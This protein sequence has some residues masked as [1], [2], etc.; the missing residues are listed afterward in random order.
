MLPS[1]YGVTQASSSIRKSRLE[2]KPSL[3]PKPRRPGSTDRLSSEAKRPSA[4]GRSSSADPPRATFTGVRLSREASSTK[5]PINARSRSQQG[6]R[7]GQTSMTPLRSG[8]YGRATTTPRTPSEDRTNRSWQASLDRALAFVTVKDQRTISNVAWQ[9]AEYARVQEALTARGGP[10]GAPLT[11]MKPLTIARFVDVTGS[12]LAA[13]TGDIRLNNDNYVTKLPHIAKRLLYPGTLSKSWLKTVNALHAFPQALAFIAY[14]LDLWLFSGNDEL[15]RLRREYLHRCW[16]RFQDPEPNYEMFT[17]EYL[18]NLKV[19]LGN[20]EEK[21]ENLQQAVKEYK[22]CLEDEV[23]AAARADEARRAERRDALAAALRAERAAR[24]QRAADADAATAAGRDKAHHLKQLDVDIERA[25]AE[26]NQLKL[27]V[28][29]QPISI[30]ERAR[31]REEVE[32]TNRVQASKRALAEQIEK[33]VTSKE[34]ELAHWQTIALVSCRE[35]KQGLIHLTAQFP[36]IAALAV[37][38]NELMREECVSRV[39]GAVEALRLRFQELAEKRAVHQRSKTAL[40]RKMAALVEETQAMIVELKASIER[41]Q[42]LLEVD[43][44]KEASE[45]ATWSSEHQELTAKIEELKTLQEEYARIDA[46]LQF[47]QKQDQ[48]W[49]AKLSELQEFIR[50][51]KEE[52]KKLLEEGRRKRTQTLV[53]YIRVW[54]SKVPS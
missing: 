10:G 17:E 50:S 19:L 7:Y 49:R 51:K 35:Y 44:A 34:S 14:L 16:I 11:L 27:E 23:E 2:A 15:A 1:R 26:N 29:S 32:Y 52:S 36:D 39:C 45:A 12:L 21:I 40:A 47:W 30:E 46:D 33:M 6:D 53:D 13:I 9:R 38:E 28:E 42:Q 48:A 4:A 18:Q 25:I 8:P 54:N 24:R 31:L 20:D 22:S 41:E 37:D 43:L 5:L 3:L